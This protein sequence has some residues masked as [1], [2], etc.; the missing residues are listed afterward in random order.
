[1]RTASLALACVLAAQPAAAADITIGVIAGLTGL[2]ASYGAGIVHG[3]QMA[4]QEINAAGGI[5]GRQI[6]LVIADDATSPAR[7][8]VVMRRLV[9]SGVDLIVGGWGSPQVIANMEI[10]EQAGVPYI[11]VGATNPRITRAG[12]K[13]TFRVIQTDAA[14][15]EQ[16]AQILVKELGLSRIAVINDSNDYGTGNRDSFVAALGRHGIKPVETQS[17]QTEDR[18][19]S[20]QL[21]RIR[22]AEPEAIA[23][24]GTIP[25]APAIMNQARALGLTARF[26]GTGGLANELLL[27]LAPAASRGTVLTTYFSEE[28]DEEAEAW[29][30]RYRKEFST[31]AAPARPVLAAWEYRAIRSIVA[32]CLAGIGA[33]R[34]ALRDCLAHWRGRMF[35]IP[36]ELYFDRSGQLVQPPVIVEVRDGAFRLL[37]TDGA[38]A[39]DGAANPAR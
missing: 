39:A 13:W 25:A 32:P 16:L 22:A 1:L 31:A 2:G 21:T 34:I 12:N 10:A 20:A 8:A 6:R 27:S 23:I 36:A 11:I 18:D 26:V 3:A 30:E 29:A 28:I 4:A 14:M 35:G 9:T 15:S 19:F 24:F 17:Y 7:S 38:T 33:D 37:K 5:D